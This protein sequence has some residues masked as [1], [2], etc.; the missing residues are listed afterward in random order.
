MTMTQLEDFALNSYENAEHQGPI[1]LPESLAQK[2]WRKAVDFLDKAGKYF[3]VKLII[4]QE[5]GQVNYPGFLLYFGTPILLI[6]A[7][8]LTALRRQDHPAP[9]S[10]K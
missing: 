4:N 1:P 2:T 10:Q 7:V 9:P 8:L 5:T 3:N 6:F